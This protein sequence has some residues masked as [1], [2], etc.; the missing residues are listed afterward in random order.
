MNFLSVENLTK[1]FGE[2]ALFQNINFGLSQGDK[3]ALVARNGSGKTTLINILVGK[4]VPDSGEAA[5]NKD[6]SVGFLPQVPEF[7]ESKTVIESIFDAQNP[8][9]DAIKAYEQA[10]EEAQS[11]T[12]ES[13]EKLQQASVLMDD[14]KAWDF[15]VELKKILSK[16]NITNLN[17]EVSVLSG[18][19][20]KRV[21]LAKVILE[22]P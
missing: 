6:I 12:E 16:L 14:L 11:G 7:D 1:S 18:G 4:D 13:I 17:A 10:L 9:I 19:Q 15:E 5:F 20:R 21:A 2:K 8:M 22:K 3:T